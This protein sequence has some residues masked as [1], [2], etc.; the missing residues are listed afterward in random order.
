[1]SS[2]ANRRRTAEIQERAKK[3]GV[4]LSKA[5]QRRL[6]KDKGKSER[7]QNKPDD[8]EGKN[9]F[10]ALPGGLPS[11]SDEFRH[12]AAPVESGLKAL[13][14]GVMGMLH[15]AKRALGNAE[16]AIREHP[17]SIDAAAKTAIAV[18]AVGV[19]AVGVL[20]MA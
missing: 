10:S 15:S 11:L 7:S 8:S 13:G 3:M 4:P 16:N 5:E 19:L 6:A 17:F 2:K 1:M 12:M 18:G 20:A 9:D 14:H